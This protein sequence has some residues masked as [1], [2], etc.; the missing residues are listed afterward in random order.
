MR[1]VLD[2]YQG[3]A[4]LPS[5]GAE[6]KGRGKDH[7][8]DHL[9]TE[10]ELGLQTPSRRVVF[11]APLQMWKNPDIKLIP[12]AHFFFVSL[13][14]LT[15]K[16]KRYTY[17]SKLSHLAKTMLCYLRKYHSLEKNA[18]EKFG[19]EDAIGKVKDLKTHTRAHAHGRGSGCE[20]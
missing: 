4:P 5:H 12:S 10:L 6:E 11:K 16:K 15:L 18:F 3:Q 17:Y 9:D 2:P 7:S 20:S 19:C 14:H 1:D 8:Q 13:G